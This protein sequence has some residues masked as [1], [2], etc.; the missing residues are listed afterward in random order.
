LPIRLPSAST[1]GRPINSLAY[2]MLHLLNQTGSHELSLAYPGGVG[3]KKL[4]R[5][6]WL[7]QPLPGS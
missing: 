3:F 6:A 4:S 1:T 7:K 2:N 5:K